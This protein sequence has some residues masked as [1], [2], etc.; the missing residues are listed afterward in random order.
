[1][2]NVKGRSPAHAGS[3][4]PTVALLHTGPFQLIM[5]V[6]R[7]PPSNWKSEALIS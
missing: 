2:E 1:M 6:N 3:V 7:V 4:T 5:N